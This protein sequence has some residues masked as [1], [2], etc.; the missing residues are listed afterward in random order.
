MKLRAP[1]PR[2]I[3]V[4]LAFVAAA[5]FL[6]WAGTDGSV[7]LAGMTVGS[8]A[9][10][11]GLL[12]AGFSVA[13]ALSMLD[14]DEQEGIGDLVAVLGWL[15]LLVAAVTIFDFF[16]VIGVV[17]VLGAG[18]YLVAHGLGIDSGHAGPG[19]S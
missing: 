6:V 2:E 18:A 12:V 15:C 8:R 10:A 1:R 19:T 14:G 17:L 16:A 5:L 4:G 3:V 11:A 7:R 13:A 9:V